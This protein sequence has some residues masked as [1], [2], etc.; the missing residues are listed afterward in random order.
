LILGFSKLSIWLVVGLARR[1]GTGILWIW[2]HPWK[3][4]HSLWG[5]SFRVATLLSVSYLVYDRIYEADVTISA[6]ASDPN[7]PFSFPFTITNNSH[8]FAIKN[9]TWNCRPIIIKWGNGNVL[10]EGNMIIRGVTSVIDAG[11]NLNIDCS[12]IGP[13]SRFMHTSGP[14][15]I[16]AATLA[17]EVSYKADF[18]SVFS[19][20]RHPTPSLFTWF[21]NATNPQWIKGDFA[22]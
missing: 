15:K 8:I 14:V 22:R 10:S 3:S 20:T 13:N 21:A 17:I 5:V 7:F 4:A 19:M 11:K 1:S 12:I 16:D 6:A 2:R 18:F 9:V